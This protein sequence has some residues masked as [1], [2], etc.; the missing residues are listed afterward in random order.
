M[1]ALIRFE[2]VSVL[3][4]EKLILKEL[5]FQVSEGEN[6]AFYGKSGAGKSSVLRTLMGLHLIHSGQVYFQE[7]SLSIASIQ[8]IR[9]YTAYIGQ[10][11]MLGANTVRDALLLPFQFKAHLGHQP[12]AKTLIEVLSRLQLS[13][14]ILNQDCSR[15]S[16]GEKQRIAL[17]RGLLLGKKLYLLDEVTSALDSE[18]KAAVFEV[19]SDPELTVLSV[20]H[21]PEWLARCQVTYELEAGQL[22]KET[23]HGSA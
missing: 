22:L 7:Q 14:D 11:P 21:D 10:E 12:N 13:A 3:A 5:S 8:A 6:V 18:S 20:T 4:Q 15:I 23:R 16:G 17:A 9:S 1:C 19:F 2:L